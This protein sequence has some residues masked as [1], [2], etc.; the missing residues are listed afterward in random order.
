M[1]P[2]R[3]DRPARTAAL[4][5]ALLV[6]ALP[7]PARAAGD[8]VQ[9]YLQAAARLYESLDYDQALEQLARAKALAPR[10]DEGVEISL[11]EGIIYADMS[12]HREQSQ[13]AFRAALLLRP[14]AR[15]PVRVSPKVERD[16]EQLRRQVTQ[17]LSRPRRGGG[18]RAP[19]PGDR[20][21]AAPPPAAGPELVPA[22]PLPSSAGSPQGLS[23]FGARVPPVP[24]ALGGVAV[25][26]GVGGT[27][28]GLMTRSSLDQAQRATY[29]DEAYAHW[30]DA[31]RTAPV[32][33]T[34]FVA[35]GLLATGA[36]ATYLLLPR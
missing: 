3:E 16:F 13:A 28:L 8:D 12:G 29:Q 34:L 22:E 24:A 20:P 36:V 6:P 11:Y 10:A 17:E 21:L 31:S 33:N 25:A 26:A 35:A 4:L 7:A 32:A 30:Q 19:A 5:L 18:G 27:V 1:S 23:L 14:D 2:G 9:R 15:L